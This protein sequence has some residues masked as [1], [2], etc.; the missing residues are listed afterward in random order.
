MKTRFAVMGLA[1]ALAMPCLAQA[2][3]EEK[4]AM[5]GDAQVGYSVRGEGPLVVVIASTGR[6]SGELAP[7]ADRLS[8]RGYRVALPEPRGIGASSGKMTEVSFHDFG[9]DFAAVIEQEGGK[10]I[11]A[12]HAYGQWIAKTI[13]SDH[14]EMVSGLALIAGGA[15]SWPSELSEAITMINDPDSSR[16]QKMEGLLLAFF[17][18]E[19]SAEPWLEGWH[20]DVTVSQRAARKLTNREDYWAGGT[21]PIL[22]LQAGADPFRPE[23]SRMEVRDELGDRVTVT[24]IDGA[25]HALP[26]AKP[27]ET[28][29]AIADWADALLKK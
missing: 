11:V 6:S 18:D 23:S 2:Q 1:L 7:L 4:T 15:K 5:N 8:E 12:G 13:A 17:T 14:P 27:V 29:D 3:V 25:S 19:Q 28:A 22:D 21:A 24:V 20:Q 10:A 16:D 9:D 26:A